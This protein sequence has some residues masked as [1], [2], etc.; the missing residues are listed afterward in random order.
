MATRRLEGFET[1]TKAKLA[2]IAK[3]EIAAGIRTRVEALGEAY[4]LKSLRP[5]YFSVRDEAKRKELIHQIRQ[6]ASTA[7]G[8]NTML[9]S[10][11]PKLT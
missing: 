7:Y 6:Y 3:L 9:E 11:T 2:E 10:Q 1:A 8:T 5:I 4:F